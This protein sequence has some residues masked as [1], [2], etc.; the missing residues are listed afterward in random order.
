M[1]SFCHRTT[2]RHFAFRAFKVNACTP[3]NSPVILSNISPR[4]YK[5]SVWVHLALSQRCIAE[6]V[7]TD[8]NNVMYHAKCW[9]K[10]SLNDTSALYCGGRRYYHMVR[11]PTPLPKELFCNKFSWPSGSGEVNRPVVQSK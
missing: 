1:Q 7:I 4:Y 3:L 6:T 5:F 9:G 2:M 8:T 10:C 11:L